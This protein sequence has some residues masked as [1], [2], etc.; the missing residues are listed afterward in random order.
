MVRIVSSFPT[1]QPP[2]LWGG[3]AKTELGV[4][5]V[6]GA[7][8]T[9]EKMWGS[10]HGGEDATGSGHCLCWT[11]SKIT[12]WLQVI[13]GRKR[14]G[15][16]STALFIYSLGPLRTE[17]GFGSNVAHVAG[18]GALSGRGIWVVS[19]Y[20]PH[21]TFPPHSVR[22]FCLSRLFVKTT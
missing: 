20:L 5:K 6:W 7:S 4:H 18:Q 19:L 12:C 8:S 3:D 9:C 16:Y 1:P 15:L 10:R 2:V 13:L 14:P 17:C 22:Q 11:Q 21:P